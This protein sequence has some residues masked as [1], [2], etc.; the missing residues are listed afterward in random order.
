MI[1]HREILDLRGEW[2][3]RADVIEKDYV[4]GWLL[5]AIGQHPD[6]NDTWIF[7]GG[8]SLRKCYFETYR[9]S[10]DLD[11]TVVEDGP[12]EP[13]DLGPIFAD[14]GTWLR[15]ETGIEIVVD[16]RSFRRRTNRRGEPT[17]EGR[18]SF[19]GPSQPPQLPK[20]KLD[21]TSDEI[22]VEP[23][24]SRPVLHPYT[25][26]PVDMATVLSYSLAELHGEKLRALAERCRPRDLYDVVLIHRHPD[27]ADQASRVRSILEDKC[28]HADI[29]TPTI[30][31]IYESHLRAELEQEWENM[32]GHQL[33]H[34]PRVEDY[35]EDLTSVFAWLGGSLSVP[36]PPRAGQAGLDETWTAPAT[37]SN[38][39]VGAPLELI[40]FAGANRLTVELNYAPLG[41]GRVGWREVQPYSLRR[42]RAG[43]LLLFV[44]ND[45]GALRGYRVD[46]IRGVRVTDRRF[47]PRFLVEF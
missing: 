39:Q 7:K 8:T 9:F 31:S 32:L 4:L 5:A 6:L 12:E 33:P 34:L 40:R 23:P 26:A 46:R 36:V 10:E 22:L 14:V 27:L 42:T 28:R 2:G 29:D 45:Q 24:V 19:R 30:G 44:V 35:W 47:T 17:T 43:Q 1:P 11:F 38:W 13:A 3:L 20:V 21:L 41:S 18:V 37:V 16:D 15:E 25:D